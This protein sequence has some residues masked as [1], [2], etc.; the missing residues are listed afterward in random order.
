MDD[1]RATVFP[2]ILNTMMHQPAFCVSHIRSQ[3][4]TDML[5]GMISQRLETSILLWEG[6]VR[7]VDGMRRTAHEGMGQDRMKGE[8]Q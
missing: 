6:V 1:F 8:E 4:A 5:R 3:T 7:K 2:S